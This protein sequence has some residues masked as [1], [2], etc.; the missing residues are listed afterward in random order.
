MH[1]PSKFHLAFRE[2]GRK[3]LILGSTI[4][5]AWI[6]S[7]IAVI[8]SL[9]EGL[10]NETTMLFPL[11]VAI[12]THGIISHN[13]SLVILAA[14]LYI[15]VPLLSSIFTL[16]GLPYRLDLME[17][18]NQ[19]YDTEISYLLASLPHITHLSDEKLQDKLQALIDQR[20]ALG[21]AWNSFI[22]GL[23]SVISLGLTLFVVFSL[24]WR[25]LLVLLATA[26]VLPIVK[27]Q[28][29]N[30]E[31]AEEEA[32]EAG[33]LS[34]HL[35]ELTAEHNAASELRLFGAR[36]FL[37]EKLY[38]ATAA[39]RKPYQRAI[40]VNTAL[41]CGY[42]IFYYLTSSI[43]LFW[44][45][46]DIWLG[47]ENLAV[48]LGAIVVVNQSGY[49]AAT[50]S[51]VAQAFART[52]RSLTRY[53]YLKD[54][55]QAEIEKSGNRKPPTKLRKGISLRNIRF[56]HPGQKT[57]AIDNLSLDLPAGTVI[58]I[59]GENGA[60][61]S[62]LVNLLTGMYPLDAGGILIDEEN[63]KDLDPNQWRQCLSAAFQ[64]YVRFKL[65]AKDSIGIG[66][67]PK[68]QDE[69]Q[70]LAALEAA[71]ATD[72]LTALP[73]GLNT[74]LGPEEWETGVGLSGGQWQRI[75]IARG[76]MRLE[77]L[78]LILDEPTSALDAATENAL[79]T[80]YIT[81]AQAARTRGAI[82]LLITHRFST[83]AAADYVIVLEK[84]KIREAGTHPELMARKGQY[85]E[86][87]TLQARGYRKF[88]ST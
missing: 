30:S 53:E 78:L 5:M 47:K 25:L 20:A 41:E 48:L 56:S 15:L 35:L 24:D 64:D 63:L 28:I 8:F 83:V 79:F 2:I 4:Q 10:A 19:Y 1:N 33:R 14:L 71:S 77:P 46:Y 50:I 32:G 49:Y 18:I 9:L 85:Y 52:I 60:G 43:V 34:T 11:F 75:A 55:V 67:L 72:I 26:T 16:Y 29:K 13:I 17:R 70:I 86:L 81:A 76:M 80:R 12:G 6:H 84:G 65:Q 3:I 31:I 22:N 58:A 36:P 38:Q 59:V 74:Y 7:K 21:W 61:K 88:D 54:Y 73:D 87:Y 51:W 37:L 39:W 27:K 44:L 40:N 82:T 42:Q 69:E 45:S 23:R 57:P 68:C 66:D 62:T